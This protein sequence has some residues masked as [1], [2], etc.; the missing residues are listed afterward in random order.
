MVGLVYLIRNPARAAQ[1]ILGTGSLWKAEDLPLARRCPAAW[2]AYTLGTIGSLYMHNTTVV[3]AAGAG[4]AMLAACI[5]R[6]RSGL[7]IAANFIATNI[8]V[9]AVW[10]L[11]LSTELQQ[12]QAFADASFWATFPTSR[13]LGII[14][15]E[16]YLMTAQVPSPLAVL[17]M[18]AA[19]AGLWALRREPRLALGM[20]VLCVAGPG[21]L[22]LVSLYKPIFGAR[23]LLWA[24]APFA[25]LVGAGVASA[26][27]IVVPIAVS[28]AV[29]VLVWPTLEQQYLR[30]DK[31]PWR[32]LVK[33]LEA[34]ARPGAIA[35][36]AS[37]E[38]AM[39]LSY[40]R[41]RRSFPVGTVPFVTAQRT[42]PPEVRE[43]AEVFLLDR[44][45]GARSARA[46]KLLQSKGFLL[47]S[48]NS[49]RNLRLL[50]L[51]PTQ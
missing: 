49:F 41:Q 8:I 42:L 44:K 18:A 28:A 37:S 12:A 21:L 27:R 3:F 34:S 46:A 32:E 6:G 23:M 24:A 45:N 36:A 51:T 26:R 30:V 16:L 2:T 40:Y 22:L 1:P 48:T 50:K 25:A 7:R 11:Y 47:V 38:E 20:V 31:E 29:A 17:L 15:R 33:T 19:L 10:G 39:M 35:V 4:L 5:G 9:L 13:E 14:A 43:A